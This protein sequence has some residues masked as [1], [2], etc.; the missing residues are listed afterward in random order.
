LDKF[1]RKSKVDI[2][3]NSFGDIR[4]FYKYTFILDENEIFMKLTLAAI[5]TNF[6]W[7]IW[8]VEMKQYHKF[9]LNTIRN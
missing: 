9:N 4:G 7:F 8:N 2:N 6:T 1:F 3:N 5:K